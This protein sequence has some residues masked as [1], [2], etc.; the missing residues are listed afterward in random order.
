M[1]ALTDDAGVWYFYW[2]EAF[3]KDLTCASWAIV[4][5]CCELQREGRRVIKSSQSCF[6]EI[7]ALG[8]N[9]VMN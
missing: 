1:G 4:D 8:S 3:L 7:L 9:D 5:R 2:Y 6:D